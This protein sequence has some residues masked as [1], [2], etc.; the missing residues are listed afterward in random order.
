MVSGI[1]VTM[2]HEM[3]G[4]SIVAAPFVALGE[5]IGRE[6]VRWNRGGQAKPIRQLTKLSAA[7][8]G[9]NDNAPAEQL[10]LFG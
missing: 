1:P 4:Q 5:S 3:L 6:M 2:A 9:N 10:A 8:S 7:A